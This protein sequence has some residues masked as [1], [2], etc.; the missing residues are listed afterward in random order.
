[1]PTSQAQEMARRANLDLVEVAS[2]AVPPVCRLLDYGKYR[3]E[4]EKKEREL[5]KS[6]KVTLVR[7]IRIRPKIGDHDFDAKVRASKKLLEEGDKVRVVIM[8]R[9]REITHPDLGMK[10]LQRVVESL[11][12]VAAIEK[13]PMLD[14]KRMIMVLSGAAKAKTTAKETATKTPEKVPAMPAAPAEKGKETQHAKAKNP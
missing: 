2:T 1:M 4:Q 7:E 14:G 5:R 13:Q 10:L 11:Q 9:G 8:F 6:Q 3:Y 12:G